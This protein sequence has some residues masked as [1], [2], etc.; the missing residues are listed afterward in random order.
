MVEMIASLEVSFGSWIVKETQQATVV[1]VDGRPINP[2]SVIIEDLFTGGVGLA[3]REAH[4][5][6][7]VGWWLMPAG[8]L[9]A[10][11]TT[12][13]FAGEVGALQDSSQHETLPGENQAPESAS[14]D[15]H[16][17]THGNPTLKMFRALI[18]LQYI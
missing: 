16:L 2:P 6:P 14:Q 15:S 5:L 3:R 13:N 8:S 17:T 4:N 18:H 7:V 1:Q 11:L 9:V 12:T 10:I